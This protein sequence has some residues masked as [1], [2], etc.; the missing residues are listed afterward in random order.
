MGSSKKDFM[1]FPDG[2]K[3][4]MGHALYIAQKGEKHR[5]AKPLKGFGGGSVIE[6][7]QCDARGTYRTVYTVQMEKAVIILH[8]F[9]KKSKTGIQTPKQEIDLVEQRLRTAHQKYKE[10][11]DTLKLRG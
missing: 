9:Q 2:V 10:W 8:A 7:I 4:E 3:N 1:E 11:L 5:D 6:I